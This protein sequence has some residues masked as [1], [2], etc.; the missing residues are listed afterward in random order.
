LIEGSEHE[1]AV[2]VCPLHGF[3]ARQAGDN[4]RVIPIA[5]TSAKISRRLLAQDAQSKAQVLRTGIGALS[6][7]IATIS[8]PPDG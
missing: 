4:C 5:A 6:T 3:A 7:E 1:A 2:A 8:S